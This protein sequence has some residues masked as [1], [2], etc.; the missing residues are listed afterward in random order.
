MI[1][2]KEEMDAKVRTWRVVAVWIWLRVREAE[3]A[4]GRRARDGRVIVEMLYEMPCA[5]K[6][7]GL[8]TWVEKW[9]DGSFS[10]GNEIMMGGTYGEETEGYCADE[11][12][13]GDGGRHLD[14]WCISR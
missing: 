12:C 14:R 7:G 2:D 4:V 5:Y 9:V 10:T 8:K 1:R 3:E 13:K 11:L 6:L